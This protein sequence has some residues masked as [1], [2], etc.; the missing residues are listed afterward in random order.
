MP[1]LFWKKIAVDVKHHMCIFE[2]KNSFAQ[3]DLLLHC[4]KWYFWS[5]RILLLFSSDA[6]LNRF[7]A[8]KQSQHFYLGQSPFYGEH[9]YLLNQMDQTQS[10]G[11]EKIVEIPFAIGTK[12]IFDRDKYLC[13]FMGS[14]SISLIKCI[15]PGQSIG[16]II[17]PFA[18][19]HRPNVRLKMYSGIIFR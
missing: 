2:E 13:P 8:G 7:Q 17:V 6:S 18:K 19:V 4:W 3:Q 9:Q 14:T 5:V 11:Q 1:F 10:I 15:N 16:K 12:S